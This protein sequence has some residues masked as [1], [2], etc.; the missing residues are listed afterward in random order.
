LDAFKP[1]AK[2]APK[3]R[4]KTP[5]TPI[6][7]R[8]IIARSQDTPGTPAGLST[9]G[10]GSPGSAISDTSLRRSGRS[11]GKVDYSNSGL[12]VAS[13][14]R[15]DSYRAASRGNGTPSK[16]GRTGGSD[17]EGDRDLV[18]DVE[19]E[20]EDGD[21]GLQRKAQKLGVRL[22][23][24]KTFGSIPGVE[25]GTWWPS[26]MDCSTAAIHA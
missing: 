12:V 15:Q 13:T 23:D 1:K 10:P 9:D 22:F 6:L 24:P 8:T 20:D 11:R 19:D 7:R 16:R 2:P 14:S 18:D 5:K 3:P 17:G 21:T 25:V 26:R 4:P